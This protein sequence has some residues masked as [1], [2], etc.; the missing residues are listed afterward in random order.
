MAK[1]TNNTASEAI[2]ARAKY[3]GL[4][5]ANGDRL[6]AMADKFGETVRKMPA[7]KAF[8]GLVDNAERIIPE[9]VRESVTDK[10]KETL[11]TNE[12]EEESF[13][14]KILSGVTDIS[15]FFTESFAK[16][17]AFVGKAIPFET[18]SQK[19]GIQLA[20]SIQSSD[21]ALAGIENIAQSAGISSEALQQ[22][23]IDTLSRDDAMDILNSYHLLQENILH[24]G[25]QIIK[26]AIGDDAEAFDDIQKVTNIQ[27]ERLF[28]NVFTLAY[29]ERVAQGDSSEAALLKANEVAESITGMTLTQED[30]EDVLVASEK[31]T[32][33]R[34]T[35]K[36]S[37][38]AVKEGNDTT[39]VIATADFSVKTEDT[40]VAAQEDVVQ[41]ATEATSQVTTTVQPDE[42]YDAPNGADTVA[43]GNVPANQT[44]KKREVAS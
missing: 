35:L 40:P 21:D 18:N 22:E 38:V 2:L 23:I 17:T 11:N 37:F 31:Y 44:E 34:N 41:A 32:G 12:I 42:H 4:E 20:D 10:A 39:T 1:E 33:L 14:G 27:S 43:A 13:V 19:S 25:T 5:G 3:L 28:N 6:F 16:L 30:G 24:S 29:E 15:K 7:G 26:K 36:E 9:D 8:F